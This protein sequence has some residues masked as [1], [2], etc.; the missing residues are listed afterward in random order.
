MKVRHSVV[1]LSVLL[2]LSGCSHRAAPTQP[3]LA[4]TA[5][6]RSSAAPTIVPS[7]RPT[8]TTAAPPARSSGIV[9]GLGTTLSHV[10]RADPLSTAEAFVI[11]AWTSD[12]LVDASPADAA[13]R[14][15]A[16][17]TPLLARTLQTPATAGSSWS[18][19]KSTHGWTTVTVSLNTDDGG[20][21]S[22][23]TTHWVALIAAIT[24]HPG[25]ATQ[26]LA[27]YLKLTRANVAADWAV[28][29]FHA[30][31]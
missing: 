20:P 15:S 21:T 25:T 10:N 16:L 11:A 5:P 31:S 13:R 19:L 24:T 23:S 18:T 30:G 2:T 1:T 6:T 3:S 7:A 28:A 26:Q 22:T 12:T 27:L 17:A 4:T 8:S 29:A 9:R 14:A